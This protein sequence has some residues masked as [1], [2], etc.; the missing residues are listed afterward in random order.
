MGSRGWR[1]QR[2]VTPILGDLAKPRRAPPAPWTC[3]WL[4]AATWFVQAARDG[5][6][7]R[8]RADMRFAPSGMAR[9]PVHQGGPNDEDA[10]HIDSPSLLSHPKS[11]CT[12]V[13]KAMPAHADISEW[14]SAS[15]KTSSTST[16]VSRESGSTPSE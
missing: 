6:W 4:E 14:T 11:P 16:I 13:R 1:A 7:Y 8:R 9:A 12:D 10:P 15:S 3:Q 5:Y 2:G